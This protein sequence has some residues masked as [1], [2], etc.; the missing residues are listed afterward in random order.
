M[1]FVDKR[2]SLALRD[3]DV[4][5]VAGP[6]GWTECQLLRVNTVGLSMSAWS[7]SCFNWIFT[8]W[9]SYPRSKNVNFLC[10]ALLVCKLNECSCTFDRTSRNASPSDMAGNELSQGSDFLHHV[11]FADA[12]TRSAVMDYTRTSRIGLSAMQKNNIIRS[13]ERSGYQKNRI[14]SELIWLTVKKT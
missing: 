6:S 1:P 2:E 9:K 4:A 12:R 8:A 14:N 3:V 13:L 7:T 10:P 11:K 5:R